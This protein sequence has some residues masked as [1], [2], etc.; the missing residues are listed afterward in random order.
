M[1]GSSR[2]AEAGT[3]K[4][5]VLDRLGER[6]LDKLVSLAAGEMAVWSATW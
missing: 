3:T 6:K 5:A 2:R 1:N 4:G